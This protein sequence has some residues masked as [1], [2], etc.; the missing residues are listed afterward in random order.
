MWIQPVAHIAAY[1]SDQARRRWWHYQPMRRI[2]M[3]QRNLY[4]AMC[5]SKV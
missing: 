5:R 4:Q 2:I 1:Y 3:M